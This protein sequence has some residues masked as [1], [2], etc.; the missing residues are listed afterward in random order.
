MLHRKLFAISGPRG[1]PIATPS[2]CSYKWPLNWNNWFFAA[3]SSSCL[4]PAPVR[5]RLCVL[6]NQSFSNALVVSNSMVSST[7][8]FVKSEVTS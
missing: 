7:G 8:T 4:S 2:F 6:L 1:K 5:L 3:I